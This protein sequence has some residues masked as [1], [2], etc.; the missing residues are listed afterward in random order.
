MP[1]RWTVVI[2]S[3]ITAPN[4]ANVKVTL[5]DDRGEERFFI[6]RELWQ[7][8][9]EKAPVKEGTKVTESLYTA[10]CGLADRTRAVAEA[11]RIIAGSDKSRKE[12]EKKLKD[13]GFSEKHAVYATAAYVRRGLL[14]DRSASIRIAEKEVRNKHR[15]RH[16]V[17]SYLTSRGFDRQ[18]ARAAADAVAGE[19]YAEALEY[20]IEHRYPGILSKDRDEKRKAFASLVRMG[21]DTGD[22]WSCADR[23][24]DETGR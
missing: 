4:T 9:L 19:L 14:D 2:K 22:I 10:I 23:I 16:R 6:L 8:L 12:I 1:G 3:I 21:F 13:K 20:N 24:K 15:G 17:I 18:D 7:K 11:G 5:G